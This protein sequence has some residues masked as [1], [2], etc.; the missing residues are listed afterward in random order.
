MFKK[1]SCGCVVLEIGTIFI[2]ID[3]CDRDDW[4]IIT[5]ELMDNDSRIEDLKAKEWRELPA[6]EQLRYLKRIGE[7]FWLGEKFREL[8]K[9]LAD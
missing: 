2:M 8:K 3:A 1:Y 9:I 5:F 4:P 6:N 7:N